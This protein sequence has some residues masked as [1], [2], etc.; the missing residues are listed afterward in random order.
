MNSQ[1]A[2]YW[3]VGVATLAVVVAFLI[4]G[5][6]RESKSSAG[7][8]LPGLVAYKNL[9]AAFNQRLRGV[10]EQIRLRPDDMDSVR[11][12]ARLYHANGLYG[13]ARS[14]YTLLA[15]H[16]VGLNARDHYYLADIAQ[17]ESNLTDT[18]TELRASLVTGPDYLPARLAL[19]N[20]LFKSGDEVAAGKEYSAVL[21]KQPDQPQA[22]LGL[23]RIELQK[24]DDAA[25]SARL[26]ELL[27]AHPESTGAA[28]LFAQVLERLGQTDRAV[29]VTQM[30]LQKPE[31]PLADPWM[32]ELLADCYDIQRLSI[33]FEE[34]FKMG[35]MDGAL[36]LLDRLSELDPDNPT[37]K[38]FRGFSH[39][40]AG[41]HSEATREF[42]EAL[43]KGGDPEKI[44]PYLVQSLFDQGKDA[45]AENLLAG[46][47]AKLPD[48]VPLAKAYSE[49]ATRRGD[50]ALVRRLLTK[51]LEKEPY[52]YPQ[53]MSLAKILWT[54]GERDEAAKYLER[55]ASVYASDVPSRALLGE[56]FLSKSDPVSALKFLEQAYTHVAAGTPAHTGLTALLGTAHLQ[57]GNAEIERARLAEAADHYEKAIRFAPAEIEAYA[58]KAN[59]CVQ[60]KQFSRAAE[61]LERL[62]SLL[63]ENPTI[64]LSLGDVLYQGG[65]KDQAGGHWHKALQLTPTG[66]TELRQAIDE[67]LAGRITEETFK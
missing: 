51:V 16:S 11:K 39:A 62:T 50:A 49:V 5:G 38:I 45:E 30:S 63:P 4:H 14:C 60:L 35:Q 19:A 48:S 61:A 31:P 29:A 58:G 23:A 55:V 17:N 59:A 47:S 36:P 34:F 10:F 15:V 24:G 1:R 2:V 20:A 7:P 67:R 65:K 52:L 40:R 41:R 42:R 37:I 43:A 8:Q 25:A 21:Q 13:E 32:T 3:M 56:Y 22:S 33:A 57:A 46:Y 9:P 54:S 28:S 64:H 18:E 26:E 66:D 12:L 27:A 53:N 6:G 44:C